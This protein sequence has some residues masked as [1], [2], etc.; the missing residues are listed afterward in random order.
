MEIRYLSSRVVIRGGGKS[1]PDSLKS[2]TYWSCGVRWSFINI[3]I[4]CSLNLNK[5]IYSVLAED[6]YQCQCSCMLC[7]D[8]STIHRLCLRRSEIRTTSRCGQAVPITFRSPHAYTFHQ[9]FVSLTG[10]CAWIEIVLLIPGVVHFWFSNWGSGL[11]K[12]SWDKMT[13]EIGKKKKKH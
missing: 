5:S 8:G 10:L 11:P 7:T 13:S 3:F 4:A 1:V 12:G 9:R 6:I 2:Q